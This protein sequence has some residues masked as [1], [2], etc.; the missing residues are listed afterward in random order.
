M[1]VN[2]E[3]MALG[4]EALR[5]GDYQQARGALY[6]NGGYCCLGV[7]C[8]VAIRHGLDIRVEDKET[9]ECTKPFVHEKIAVK[10]YDGETCYLPAKV[11]EWYGLEWDSYSNAAVPALKTNEGFEDSATALNDARKY[12][13]GQIADAFENTFMRAE[14]AA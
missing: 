4:I 3:R 11:A 6:K 8:D 2:I 10:A 14:S 7:L 1:P 12:T 5:S 13:F 9:T